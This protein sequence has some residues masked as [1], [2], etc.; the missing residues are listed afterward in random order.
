MLSVAELPDD[1]MLLK[2]LLVERDAEVRQRNAAIVER[3]AQIAQREAMIEQIKQEAAER[4]EALQRQHQAELEALLRRFYGPRS[5]R[6]DPRQ[7]LLFGLTIDN[8]AAQ[9]STQPDPAAADAVN[10][11]PRRH[12]HGRGPLP[13]SLRRIIIPHDLSDEEKKCP[14]CGEVR[15]RIGEDR[16]EQIERMPAEFVVLVH[17]QSKY[18]CPNCEKNGENPQIEVAPKPLQPIHRG[19]PGP[20]LLAFII[21]SKFADHVPLYRLEQIFSREGM[22]ISRGTMHDVRVAAGGGPA[23]QA[24][25]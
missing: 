21:V 8:L 3:E 1:P 16:T 25:V 12:N 24:P 4:I 19:L 22:D 13:A 10:R 5:E 7:L 11:Q 20:I 2:R 6:F 9:I 15:C 23:G 17:V 18:A 14:C